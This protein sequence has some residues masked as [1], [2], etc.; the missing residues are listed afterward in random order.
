MKRGSA[1]PTASA[2]GVT[3][4]VP[5]VGIRLGSSKERSKKLTWVPLRVLSRCASDAVTWGLSYVGL[6]EAKHMFL[7][8]PHS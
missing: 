6:G 4:E 1:T 7:H 2:V 3:S 8:V 5:I